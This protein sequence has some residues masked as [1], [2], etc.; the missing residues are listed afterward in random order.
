M[1]QK[2][3][4][5]LEDDLDGSVATQTIKFS[6]GGSAYE[7]DLNDKNTDRL[8]KALAPFVAAARKTGRSTNSTRRT[9]S[10]GGSAAQIRAGGSS[11]GLT[12][13]ARGRIPADVRSAYDEAH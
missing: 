13:P 7:I 10:V 5:V 11:G 4:I 6:I 8:H 9:P 12:V 3:H 2:V 1:A